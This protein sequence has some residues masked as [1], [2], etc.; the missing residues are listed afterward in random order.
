MDLNLRDS[1]HWGCKGTV[2]NLMMLVLFAISPVP[3]P[4]DPINNSFIIFKEALVSLDN[5]SSLNNTIKKQYIF[6]R[7]FCCCFN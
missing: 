1:R 5:D 2:K 4:N 7:F 3:V 6:N